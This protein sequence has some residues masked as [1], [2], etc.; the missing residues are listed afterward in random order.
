MID[1]LNQRFGLQT[2]L[3]R[4][5]GQFGHDSGPNGLPGRGV[6][7]GGYVTVPA[8]HKIQR[9]TAKRY[10]SSS[11]AAPIIDSLFNNGFFQSCIPQSDFQYSWVTGSIGEDLTQRI[12]G[13]APAGGFVSSSSGF[14]DA[15]VFPSAS[16]I[17]GSL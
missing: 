4:H 17:L 7:S 10:I 1:H 13:F 8:F 5:C 11:T 16:N 15:I 12:L 3:R 14:V 2:H 6:R 9:N